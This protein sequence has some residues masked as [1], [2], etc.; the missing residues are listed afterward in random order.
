MIG[1]DDLKHFQKFAERLVLDAGEILLKEQGKVSI[2]EYKDSQD[3][4]TSADL[5]SEKYII[6]TILSKYPKHGIISEERGEINKAPRPTS[7]DEIFSPLSWSEILPKQKLIHPRATSLPGSS[8]KE[9]EGSKYRWV[10]DPLDGTKDFIRNIPLYNVSLALE[11][12][13]ELVVAV[14]NCPADKSLYSAAKGIGSFLNGKRIKVSEKKKLNESF[15]CCYLPS[16]KRNKQGYEKSWDVLTEIGKHVYQ[17][18]QKTTGFT[19]G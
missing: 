12:E 18:K 5:A 16:F 10:I 8:A 9:D 14:V 4:A 11:L 15:V 7:H 17:Q 2:V 3:N 13:G 6:D 1:R 19:R